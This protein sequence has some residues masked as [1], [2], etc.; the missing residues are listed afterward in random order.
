MVSGGLGGKAGDSAAT[1]SFAV[2]RRERRIPPCF[3]PMIS[4]GSMVRSSA[5]KPGSQRGCLYVC[6]LPVQRAIRKMI[7][8]DVMAYLWHWETVKHDVKHDVMT[9]EVL[10]YAHIMGIH[11]PM[12]I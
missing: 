6:V 3:A 9:H 12:T 4:R 8:D 5:V 1:E 7:I 11:V 2:A 10:G